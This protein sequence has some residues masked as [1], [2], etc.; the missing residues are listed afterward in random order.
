MEM[1]NKKVPLRKCVGCCEMKPKKEL[2][3]VVRSPEGEISLDLT[4][5]KPGIQ[6]NRL[7]PINSA[8]YLFCNMRLAD[9]KRIFVQ[10]PSITDPGTPISFILIP[11]PY[12]DYVG[13][14]RIEKVLYNSVS[15]CNVDIDD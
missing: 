8:N 9:C 7:I 13:A 11:F 10:I 1:Q 6:R 3:R 14:S 15:H 4:S 2:V 5:R 12:L